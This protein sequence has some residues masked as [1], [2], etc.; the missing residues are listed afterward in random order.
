MS[1]NKI[2]H[3]NK[4][5]G[6]FISALQEREIALWVR[7]LP[8]TMVAFENT[9]KFL[10]LPWRFVVAEE[11]DDDLLQSLEQN[12]S[13]NDP[14]VRKRGYVQ[15]VD[16]DPSRLELPQ[17][18]LPIYLLNGRD[19]TKKGSDFENRLRKMNILESVRRSGINDLLVISDNDSP[20]PPDLTDLWSSDFRSF[21]SFVANDAVAAQ[22]QLEKWPALAETKTFATLFDFQADDFIEKVTSEYFDVFPEHRQIVRVKDFSGEF[23]RVDLTD[24]EEPERPILNWYSLIEERELNP[25]VPEELT[26]EDF[27]GFFQNAQA[28]WRPFAAGLPWLRNTDSKSKL[29]NLLKR[30]DAQGADENCI[31]YIASESGAGGTTLARQ[32]AWEVAK[33][34]YPVL[35]AKPLPFQVEALPIENYLTNALAAI[36][37]TLAA[38]S[39]AAEE[40]QKSANKSEPPPRRYECPW[41]I[42][43]D[44]L[45]WQ[46]RESELV[47]FR[48]ELEL[49]GRPVCILI[50]TAPV[51]AVPLYNT[52][53]FKKIA[54]QNHTIDRDEARGLGKHLNR[55]LRK[56]G[57]ERPEWQWDQFY[58]DHTVRYLEGFSAFWVT[59]SFWIQGQYDLSESIQEWM[60]RAFKK[61][62]TDMALQKAIL[63]IAALSSERLPMPEALFSNID[64]K[65]PISHL[66]EDLRSSLGPL[67]LIRLSS[68]GTKYW[69]LV[70][71]ILGRF[72]INASFYD[73][74]FRTS[75]GFSEARDAEHLRFLLLKQIS[76]KKILGERGFLSLGEDFATSIFKID[77]DHGRGSFAPFW[78]EVLT[79]LDAMPRTLR[80]TSRVFRHHTAISR[81]RIAKL[82][83]SFYDVDSNDRLSLLDEAIEDINYALTFIDYTP[84]SESNLNL[85][86]SL[87]NAYFDLAEV[88]LKLGATAERILE[89]RTLANDATRKAYSESPTNAFVIETYVRNLLQNAK[90][91]RGQPA[92]ESCIE[93]LGI[94]FSALTSN[95]VTYRSSHLG[96]LADQ[97]LS[98]LLNEIPPTGYS[99]PKNP[100]EVLINAWRALATG[101]SLSSEMVLSEVP[102]QN[103]K[104]AMASLE[105]PS[106]R[107]NMQVLRLT[108]DLVSIDYPQSLDR[109]LA[110]TE[111]LLVSNYRMTPQLRLEYAVLLF[112]NDRAVEGDKAFRQL[113]RL[114]RE[115]E[116]FVVV[117]ERMRWLLSKDKSGPQEVHATNGS[118]YGDRA[119]ARVKEFANALVPFRPEEHGISRLRPGMPLTCLV[120]F[121]HNGPF[122][123]PVTAY[124]RNKG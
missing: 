93:A 118:D 16:S 84:G 47:R 43:F 51:L 70:H 82:E 77:P 19:S 121:G 5:P 111:Q 116:H 73:N 123:R 33:E 72:L 25:L 89:L 94:L 8:A 28:S 50:V 40:H 64:T 46:A 74:P 23:H 122:L 120:S 18:S 97:A 95:G 2:I 45:H 41:L 39:K 9:K 67:G 101:A 56:Y 57:K 114:W 90:T 52:S 71:D 21:L 34:G 60:Y 81:R 3:A 4:I 62:V 68:D 104:L 29:F 106:G 11:I 112:Q 14:M 86:N 75:L 69:A 98:I 58:E 32:L 83:S 12:A 59:L 87:A 36:E 113:R 20:V 76:E 22:G 110:L 117:P 30:L 13:F 44:S 107:G 27:V 102:Q 63:E 35:L 26:E 109:Q 65:W 96:A 38:S 37:S 42:V 78:R 53:I 100:L 91:S 92:V 80:D 6:R 61:N 54:V 105:H 17:R 124:P 31:A 115:G 49:S 79:T 10:G 66:L 108:Y 88:E 85:F 55:F 7:K 48:N 103:R 15:V 1:N 24:A 119:M 99:E